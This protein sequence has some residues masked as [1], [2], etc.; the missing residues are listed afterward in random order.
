MVSVRTLSAAGLALDQRVGRSAWQHAWMLVAITMPLTILAPVGLEGQQD[1]VRLSLRSESG[2]HDGLAF[3]FV[4]P[5]ILIAGAGG[6]MSTGLMTEWLLRDVLRRAT[7]ALLVAGLVGWAMGA[8]VNVAFAAAHADFAEIDAVWRIS[9]LCVLISILIHGML[10]PIIMARLLGTQADTTTD[11][12]EA[13][14]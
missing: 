3:A 11:P 8:F 2:L 10:A 9:M 5:A 4:S 14:R 7:A 1:D 6:T 12:E 13:P